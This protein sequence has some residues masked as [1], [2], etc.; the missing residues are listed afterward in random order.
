MF[1]GVVGSCDVV[2]IQVGLHGGGGAMLHA[3]GH[4]T[5]GDGSGIGT[6][7]SGMV[8][9][10]NR[11]LSTLGDGLLVANRF[12]APR[13]GIARRTSH[14]SCLAC[15]REMEALVE[16]GT[17]PPRAVRVSVACRIVRS[18]L[19]WRSALYIVAMCQPSNIVWYRVYKIGG[20]DIFF[21]P[22][23]CNKHWSHS[24]LNWHGLSD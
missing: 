10:G 15:V 19:V 7:S 8:V 2:G 12:V 9:V 4:V 21:K 16:D 14:S 24:G 23:Q 22:G 6:L 13:R 17:V 18:M 1:E 11:G 5:L 20:I 3:L